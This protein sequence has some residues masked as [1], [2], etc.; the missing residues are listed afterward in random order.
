MQRPLR[1]ACPVREKKRR[2]ALHPSRNFAVHRLRGASTILLPQDF[3]FC[4]VVD[5]AVSLVLVAAERMPLHSFRSLSSQRRPFRA[6]VRGR[7]A[8]L[9]LLQLAPRSLSF[10]ARWRTRGWMTRKILSSTWALRTG[11]PSRP[12]GMCCRTRTKVRPL[13]SW[14]GRCRLQRYIC[15]SSSWYLPRPARSFV[16]K[17]SSSRKPRLS[18]TCSC[19]R[20]GASRRRRP[21]TCWWCHVQPRFERDF[22]LICFIGRVSNQ[23]LICQK[24]QIRGRTADYSFRGSLVM[25][26]LRRQWF[27]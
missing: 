14:H 18:Q 13:P 27:H 19:C 1:Q 5:G 10:Q 23:T 22:A 8:A 9:F 12:S 3:V 2:L 6:C 15:A 20:Q 11:G 21:M 25:M 16:S 26:L 7:L 4:F 17:Q 24:F